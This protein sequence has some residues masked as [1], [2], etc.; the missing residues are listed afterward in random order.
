LAIALAALAPT[1][2]AVAQD[3]PTPEQLDQAKKAFAEGKALH[4]QGKLPEAIEKF[5]ESYRL[6]KNPL[7]LYN[8]GLTLDEASQKDPSLKDSAL[9]YYRKFLSDA[10]AD[11]AQRAAANDRVKAL[12]KEKLEADLNGTGTPTKTEPTKT[13]PS[14]PSGKVK[15]AGTYSA[16]D[17]QHMALD[18]VP[19]G[20]PV[21]ITASVPEDSGWSVTLYY[22]G[23]NDSTFTAKAMQWRYKELVARIPAK[24]V[25]G[26]S[27]QYYLEVKDQSG[28]VVTRAGKSTDPNLVSIEAGAQPHFYMDMTDD[29]GQVSQSEQRHS[30]EEDPLHPHTAQVEP[31]ENP[32][33]ETPP[34]DQPTTP[35]NGFTDVG[36]QKFKY[37]KWG[38]TGAAVA[39]VGLGVGMYIMAGKEA[40]NLVNDTH[41]GMTPPPCRQFDT[42]YDKA[43][44]DAG[45][46][47]QTISNVG[48]VLGVGAAAVAGYFWYRELSAK[49]NGELKASAKPASP[50]TTWLVAPSIGDRFTGAAAVTRF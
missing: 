20:K 30:D 9:L 39:L 40:T 13:Q 1:R 11:A 31:H 2:I 3:A 25:A 37:T 19:P 38:T 21:D 46:N 29:G 43:Y 15:P 27:V 7:L 47:Y 14:G 48:L 33:E 16:T 44:Q 42:Q 41:C 5:K 12:E 50:E 8:I 23:S 34:V 10:P 36:S 32:G 17:F 49:K 28:T 45:H 26:N 6:S 24:K 4:D 35:G 18:T 22:R